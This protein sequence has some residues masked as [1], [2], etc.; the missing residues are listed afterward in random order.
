MD[1]AF[2]LLAP[3][4]AA[5][6]AEEQ[7]RIEAEQLEKEKRQREVAGK[8][9]KKKIQKR[10]GPTKRGPAGAG[11]KK[12]ADEVKKTAGVRCN[13]RYGDTVNYGEYLYKKVFSREFSLYIIVYF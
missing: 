13:F 6:S 1:S 8:G 7:T 5:E 12:P 2:L 4:L 10:A 3:F 11:G 9:R